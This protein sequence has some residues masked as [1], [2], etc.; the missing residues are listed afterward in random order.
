SSPILSH[1]GYSQSLLSGAFQARG[2]AVDV[3]S[4]CQM[5]QCQPCSSHGLHPDEAEN[6]AKPFFS[7]CS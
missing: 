4:Q 1:R 2:W 7:M 5:T 6:K 3:A